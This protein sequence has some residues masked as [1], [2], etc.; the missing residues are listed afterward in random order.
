M[1][2][3]VEFTADLLDRSVIADSISVCK[4]FEDIMMKQLDPRESEKVAMQLQTEIE[5]LQDDIIKPTLM[6]QLDILT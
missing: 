5:E 6:E 3:S 4:A 1:L 2:N